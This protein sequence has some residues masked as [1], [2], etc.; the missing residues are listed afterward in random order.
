MAQVVS[1]AAQSEMRIGLNTS[2]FGNVE[3]RT[4]VHATDAGV[5]IGSEK[6][7]LRSLL[8]PELPGVASALQQQNVRLT[9]VSF[10]QQGF[11]FSSDSAGGNAHSRAFTAKTN[12]PLSSPA[13]LSGVETDSEPH[14]DN[15]RSESGL[16]ILA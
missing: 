16:S 1:R 15:T 4:V 14:Y 3:V 8:A 5:S 2:S 13:E 12:V 11:A 9:H 7:D 6:G 10:Q